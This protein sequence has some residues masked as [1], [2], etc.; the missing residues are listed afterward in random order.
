MQGMLAAAVSAKKFYRNAWQVS[1]RTD[2]HK[3]DLE[4]MQQQLTDAQAAIKSTEAASQKVQMPQST[5]F[6]DGSLHQKP[7]NAA[8]IAELHPK[9][10]VLMTL[11]VC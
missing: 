1:V 8:H 6:Q 3:A 9:V 7:S 11:V 2:I 5:K 10:P 4:K